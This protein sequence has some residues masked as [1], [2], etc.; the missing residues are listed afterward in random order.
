MGIRGRALRRWALENGLQGVVPKGWA[1]GCGPQGVGSRWVRLRG[2]YSWVRGTG[3]G[4][5]LVGPRKVGGCRA[6]PSGVGWCGP[7]GEKK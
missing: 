3:V 1:P 7:K 6:G 5:M 2:V 4:P